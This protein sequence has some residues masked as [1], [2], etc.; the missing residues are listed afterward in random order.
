MFKSATVALMLAVA[1]AFPDAASAQGAGAAV[2]AAKSPGVRLAAGEVEVRARVVEL[3]RARRVAT[4]RGPKG[5]TVTIDVPAEAKNFDQVRIGDELVIRYMMA[6]L[7]R[8]E[9]AP[10]SGI[11]ERIESAG[12]AGAPAGS[13]PGG[14][15]GRTVEIVATL[16][17][18]DR[19]ARTATLRGVHRTVTVAVPEGM[20]IAKMKVGD[21]VHAV[22]V[23]AIVVKVE[24]TAASKP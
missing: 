19:K 10:R 1:S 16:Q 3:D 7:A 2:A 5:N 4:V 6:G 11:R 15:G 8:L 17:A 20:D 14:A 23:E 18:V 13:M 24:H 9:P 21:A 12:M 22:F